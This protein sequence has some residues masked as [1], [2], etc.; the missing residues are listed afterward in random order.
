MSMQTR[1]FIEKLSQAKDQGIYAGECGRLIE[2]WYGRSNLEKEIS[3]ADLA[4]VVGNNECVAAAWNKH[5]EGLADYFAEAVRLSNLTT[6]MH[7]LRQI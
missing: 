6:T 2:D 5:K 3:L 7:S 1:E 4:H